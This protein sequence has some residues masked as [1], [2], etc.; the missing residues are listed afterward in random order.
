MIDHFAPEP[1][2][3]HTCLAEMRRAGSLAPG[4]IGGG[5]RPDTRG[6]LMRWVS[7]DQGAQPLP[8]YKLLRSVDS[9]VAALSRQPLLESDLG[10]GRLLVRHEMQCTCYPG[11]GA[12]SAP[13]AP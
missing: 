10:G 6:D 7:T 3:L 5:L 13:S 9:L 4:Q 8:L 12:R 2:A 1:S 11:G